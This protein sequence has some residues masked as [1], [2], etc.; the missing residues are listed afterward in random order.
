M[1]LL[2]IFLFLFSSQTDAQ[3]QVSDF[4]YLGRLPYLKQ[5]KLIQI[6]SND[7]TGKNADFVPIGIGQT[8]RLADIKGAGV[9]TRIWVTIGADDKYFLRRLLLRMYWDGESNPSVE[10]PVG[11]FFGNGFQYT[12][13][14]SLPLGMSSGGYYCY[15]PMPFAKG[16]RIEIVNESGKKVNS[17]YYQIDYQ[18]LDSLTDSNIGRFHAQWR[19]EPRTDPK[20]NYLVLEA[21]GQGQFVGTILSMQGYRE[22]QLW[23]LEGD[24]MVYVDSEQIPSVRG[25]GTE[26]YFT[27]GWYFNRGT[28]SAPFH[29][30]IVKD[31][32]SLSRIVAYRFHLGDQ[33]PF[34]KN[35]RF[36]IEHGTNNE[37]LGD[38]SSVAFWYQTEPHK[39]FE[40]ILSA[41]RR[42]PLRAVVPEG[43]VEA[44]AMAPTANTD[45]GKIE[46]QDMSALGVDWSHDKQL[47]F[48][49]D[50]EGATVTLHLPVKEPDRYAIS[51]FISK[52]S[53]NGNVEAWIGREK[54]AEFDGYNSE[55]VPGGKVT[56]EKVRILDTTVAVTF[57][58][59]GKHPSSKGYDIGI[60]AFTLAPDRNFLRSWQV[61]G[62]FD[63]PG[64]WLSRTGLTAVYPPEREINFKKTYA[65][66][67]KKDVKWV[68]CTGGEDGF[69][70]FNSALKP[71][72]LA[73][74]YAASYLYSPRDQKVNVYLGTDDG[75]RMWV[76]DKLVR[77][78][79][80]LRGADP[81]Q[82]TVI[83]SLRKGWNK[84]LLKIENNLGGWGFFCRIPNPKDE[85]IFN[86]APSFP[87]RK[88]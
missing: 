66:K 29:G 82:D 60:D 23:F 10:C 40:P 25:T 38:Y 67:E 34:R 27:S 81:D 74:A 37:E 57:K 33:I 35:I 24:E 20:K 42:I 84:M 4:F 78:S 16:A 39:P 36:T 76:N 62:P 26:D 71:Y 22:K 6:S 48:L 58:V 5:S 68:A 2:I 70:D 61:I 73:V 31:D 65:G 28:Y 30:L 55:T 64:D 12:H 21:E 19:R 86:N 18:Q 14:T 83:V 43:A 8:S 15:F 11:D 80:I 50:K 9:I 3:T 79:L 13:W 69:V 1:V 63:N 17:F 49:A 47:R 85:L 51:A 72:E 75:V 87:K 32:T 59:V 41:T 88:K 52:D 44:E 46:V 77:D 56:F 54:V 7:T 53:T 45:G